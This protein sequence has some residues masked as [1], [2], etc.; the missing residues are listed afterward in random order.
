ML[1][2]SDPLDLCAHFLRPVVDLFL[3]VS[4]RAGRIIVFRELDGSRHGTGCVVD[5]GKHLRCRSRLV[6]FR[7]GKAR[8]LVVILFRSFIDVAIIIAMVT[9]KDPVVFVQS[10]VGG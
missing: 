2:V 8:W 4:R 3:Q 6:K 7:I 1:E 10:T 5:K 9:Y